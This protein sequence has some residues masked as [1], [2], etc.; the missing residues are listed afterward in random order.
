MYTSCSPFWIYHHSLMILVFPR[1]GWE[2]ATTRWTYKT[3]QDISIT[4]GCPDTAARCRAVQPR[5]W[6]ASTSTWPEWGILATCYWS[7]GQSGGAWPPAGGPPSSQP[8]RACR[9][10]WPWPGHRHTAPGR[11]PGGPRLD[12]A[13]QGNW[14]VQVLQ[15]TLQL[16]EGLTGSGLMEMEA[17]GN[18]WL[19]ELG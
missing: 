5:G 2:V 14:E 3:G 7:P 16:K 4:S 9:C 17:A 11:R 1:A 18:V 8:G 13:W 19:S 15:G 6:R 12:T 10:P